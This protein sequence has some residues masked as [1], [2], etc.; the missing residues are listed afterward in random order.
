MK[1][2]LLIVLVIAIAAFAISAFVSAVQP[3]RTAGNPPAAVVSD[4]G[5]K[6]HSAVENFPIAGPIERP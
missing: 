6:A 5:S 1:K 2:L 4:D 3:G